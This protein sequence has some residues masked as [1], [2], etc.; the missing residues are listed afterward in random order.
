M[1]NW[2]VRSKHQTARDRLSIEQR[3]REVRAGVWRNQSD[4]EIARN[5]GVCSAT[6]LRIRQRLNLPNFY[7]KRPTREH[8]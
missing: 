1:S 3:E 4:N 6:V 2:D 7:G 8:A 5:L